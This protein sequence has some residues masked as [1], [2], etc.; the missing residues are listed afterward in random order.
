MTGATSGIGREIAFRLA[1]QGATTVV[2]GRGDAR[3]A[4]VASEIAAASGNPSVDSIGVSDLALFGEARR[5]ARELRNR[6]P[7]LHILVN[8]AGAYFRRR[9][10]TAEGHE[11]TFALNVMAPFLLTTELESPLRAG[12]PS[13]VV[14]VSSAAH[15][16]YSVDFA[17]LEAADPYR[18]FASYGRSKLEVLLLARE[19][20]RRWPSSEV[21]VNAVHPGFVRSHFGQNNG[22]GTALGFRVLERLFGISVLRGAE[23]PVYVAASPEL[24]GVSG[25]YFARGRRS[26]GSAASRDPEAAARLFRACAELAAGSAASG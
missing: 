23:T 26:P 20:A 10:M 24:E 25:E 22:G 6:H 14:Q 16:G 18:G 2:V 15:R 11:R 3:A 1:R 12:A 4:A 19:F 7:R 9:E 13:R 8:N 5:V 17:H 21:A